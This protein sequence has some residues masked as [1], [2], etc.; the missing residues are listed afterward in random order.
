MDGLVIAL[1]ILGTLLILAFAVWLY[2][3]DKK[4]PKAMVLMCDS[5]LIILSVSVLLV[6]LQLRNRTLE[7][8][9]SLMEQEALEQ[10]ENEAIYD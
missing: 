5:L 2:L 3:V 9:R 10:M 7:E 4:M 6:G 1:I 8:N